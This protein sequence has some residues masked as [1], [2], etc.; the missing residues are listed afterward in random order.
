MSRDIDSHG[1]TTSCYEM[2][3]NMAFEEWNIRSEVNGDGRPG[4]GEGKLGESVVLIFIKREGGV[5][6][7]M[8]EVT[9]GRLNFGRV[10]D[11]ALDGR[12]CHFNIVISRLSHGRAG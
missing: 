10:D 2:G 9:E 12:P 5:S 1:Q 3:N 11:F 8:E 4:I 7:G 6:K